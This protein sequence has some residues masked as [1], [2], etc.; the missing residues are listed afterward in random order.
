MRDGRGYASTRH[1]L[2]VSWG[3]DGRLGRVGR[4]DATLG[5]PR[6]RSSANHTSQPRY[7]IKIALSAL[8]PRPTAFLQDGQHLHPPQVMDGDSTRVRVVASGAGICSL[9]TYVFLLQLHYVN[10]DIRIVL[11]PAYCCP[12]FCTLRPVGFLALRSFGQA[13]IFQGHFVFSPDLRRCF[14]RAPDVER[15][16]GSKRGGLSR[17]VWVVRQMGCWWDR[18]S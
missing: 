7:F 15:L 1:V 14:F 4:L 10:T 17:R 13:R 11:E 12:P 8:T 2:V 5:N 3:R 6:K 9:T 16:G 18:R